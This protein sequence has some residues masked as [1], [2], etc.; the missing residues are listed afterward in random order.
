MAHESAIVLLL[1]LL[2]LL[3]SDNLKLAITWFKRSHL[4]GANQLRR[5]VHLLM[6]DN[7]GVQ[8]GRRHQRSKNVK[9]S[10]GDVLH[11]DGHHVGE[12]PV[13]FGVRSSAEVLDLRIG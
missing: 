5:D 12:P 6:V 2:L 7:H 8:F 3:S 1:L 11:P 13:E 9:V 10:C 4:H